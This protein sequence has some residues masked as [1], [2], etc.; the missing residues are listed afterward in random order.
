MQ[1]PFAHTLRTTAVVA[2]VLGVLPFVLDASVVWKVLGPVVAAA[3]LVHT[4]QQVWQQVFS[5]S[6]RHLNA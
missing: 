6:P 3:L 1:Q 4:A 2:V 5:T